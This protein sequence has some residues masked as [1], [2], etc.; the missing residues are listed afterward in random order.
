MGN[1]NAKR[2]YSLG[3]RLG[4]FTNLQLHKKNL[5]LKTTVDRQDSL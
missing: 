4:M 1:I 5:F 2:F 3:G